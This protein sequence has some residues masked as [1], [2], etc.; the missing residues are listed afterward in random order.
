M[1]NMRLGVRLGVGFGVVLLL[2]AVVAVVGFTSLQRVSQS[3]AIASDVDGLVSMLMDARREE[4]NFQLRGFDVLDGDTQNAVQKLHGIVTEIGSGIAITSDAVTSDEDRRDLARMSEQVDVYQAAFDEYVT[5]EQTK[6]AADDVLV[7]SGRRALETVERMQADQH[8]KLHAEIDAGA[9]AAAVLDRV[10]KADDAVHLTE[11]MLTIRTAEK[12]FQLRHD[13]A[14]LD[15]VAATAG[16]MSAMLADLRGRFR[17]AANLEQ[18]DTI[19]AALADYQA[20]LSGYVEAFEAQQVQETRM[21]EAARMAQGAAVEVRERDAGF[22]D[23]PALALRLL[24]FLGAEAAQ[25]I[26]EVGVA[27]ATQVHDSDAVLSLLLGRVP[28]LGEWWRPDQ[29]S[30]SDQGRVAAHLDRVD[31]LLVAGLQQQGVAGL[32]Q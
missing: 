15:E 23:A 24:A 7:A 19:E 22:G 1:S 30:T 13:A 6:I 17:D 14:S 32:Q 16:D 28:T 18:V 31:G 11:W 29:A 2:T 9:D 5:L 12:N 3:A 20:A 21:I 26:V 10:E 27:V 4:K 8:D 25:E